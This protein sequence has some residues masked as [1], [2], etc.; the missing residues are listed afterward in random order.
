LRGTK[1]V[2]ILAGQAKGGGDSDDK[3]SDRRTL[4]DVIVDVIARCSE[5]YDDNVHLQVNLLF[6]ATIA[7]D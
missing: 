4:M 1:R 5:E 7:N 6:F 2:E 3:P